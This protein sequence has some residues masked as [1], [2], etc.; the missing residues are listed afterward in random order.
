MTVVPLAR[1]HRHADQTHA[2]VDIAIPV[3]NEERHLAASITALRTFLDTSFPFVATITIADNASTDATW[4]IASE[5]SATVD[6]VS[7]VRLDERGRGRALRAVWSQS[8]ASVVS[9]M[10]VDLATGLEAF[11]PLVAPL[12]SGHSDV[13]I[14]TRLG[15]GAQVV[16]GVRRELIS[17]GYN[18]LLRMALRSRCTDAQCGFKALRR[19]AAAQLLPL[20]EDDEWFFDTE[21]LVTAQRVGLRIHEVPVEWVDD[22]DSRVDVV[23]TAVKDLR[24]VARLLGRTSRRRAALRRA[25]PGR[26]GKGRPGTTTGRPAPVFAD[27]LLRFAGV[28]AVSTAAYVGLFAALQPSL[29]T[30]LGN[31]VAIGLCSVANTAA[32]RGMA[33]RA[34]VGLDRG[35]KTVVAAGLFAVN[36]GFTTGAL[37]GVR[38]MGGRRWSP[39]CAR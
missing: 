4:Q 25:G 22:T 34:R 32:H 10:D 8:T 39:D 9:Y 7:A 29:G 11:H 35:H 33:G 3:Y 37:A 17:R 23:P 18:M 15:S 1:T 36:L 24:G 14:G 13:A 19:Q 16:R 20:V 31:T 5:L 21:L 27:E 26:G 30:Y 12:L 28:G 2:D 6:G 38:A